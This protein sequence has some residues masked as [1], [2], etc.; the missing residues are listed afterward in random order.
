MQSD[1]LDVKT[2]LNI[3]R[4]EMQ[5]VM[6]LRAKVEGLSIQPA[7][8]PND[9]LPRI[10]LRAQQQSQSTAGA[11]DIAKR[12]ERVQQQLSS[13]EDRLVQLEKR[14]DAGRGTCES[15]QDV[16][17]RVE[18]LEKSVEHIAAAGN[19]IEVLS[20]NIPG[21]IANTIDA[22]MM[23]HQTAV[24]AHLQALFDNM[25]QS[26][27]SKFDTMEQRMLEST[28]RAFT[29]ARTNTH[30]D[31]AQMEAQIAAVALKLNQ[32]GIGD[33]ESMGQTKGVGGESLFRIDKHQATEASARKGWPDA[34]LGVSAQTVDPSGSFVQGASGGFQ[35]DTSD[36]I[37]QV[38]GP[39]TSARSLHRNFP[40]PQRTSQVGLH[41]TSTRS[42]VGGEQTT[43]PLALSVSVQHPVEHRDSSTSATAMFPSISA[44]EPLSTAS[45]F[46]WPSTMVNQQSGGSDL[47]SGAGDTP[48]SSANSTLTSLPSSYESHRSQT[49]SGS[50]A[51]QGQVQDNDD[52]GPRTRSDFTGMR[53]GRRGRGRGM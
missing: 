18:R 42:L 49:L 23:R 17:G 35:A 47:A 4:R 5:D 43:A 50:S 26:L 8:V 15:H 25:G 21:L 51:H 28:S 45:A 14:L 44:R 34:T 6:H 48:W 10:D 16:M 1:L 27:V 3:V 38:E 53:G 32:W 40:V 30:T 7:A 46:Q 24:G 31:L 9:S 19:A 11:S 29:E 33:R 36:R 12:V 39:P 22:V 13:H 20:H 41:P 37:F 52:A 2:S